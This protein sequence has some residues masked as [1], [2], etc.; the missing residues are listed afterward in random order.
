[1]RTRRITAKESN[2]SDLHHTGL[3]VLRMT[4]QSYFVAPA[5]QRLNGGTR[6]IINTV[7]Q[8][9]KTGHR[10]RALPRLVQRRGEL[11]SIGW[12]QPRPFKRVRG[13]SEQ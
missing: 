9:A 4:R 3:H 1:M 2:V 7:P 11:N 13:S 10:V 12:N 5:L 6:V 8:P